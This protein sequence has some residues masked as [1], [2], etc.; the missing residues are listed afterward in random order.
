M[1]AAS[2]ATFIPSK[3]SMGSDAADFDNDGYTDIVT[4]DMLGESHQRRKT[5]IAKSSFFQNI[6]NKK[7][8]YQDQH[9]RNM[10]F[11]NNGTELPFSEIGQFAGI[12]QTDWSW[13]PLFFDVDYDGDRDLLIT[14]DF[15]EI[16]RIW[17]LLT[18]N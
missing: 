7:W 17:I 12:Y 8:G 1:I 15:Q 10:L 13:A 6:L 4:L 3:F 18:I 14:T 11:K 16:S 9:M 5:T 2:G